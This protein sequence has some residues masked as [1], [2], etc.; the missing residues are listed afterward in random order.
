MN[1]TIK[2]FNLAFFFIAIPL[3]S[4]NKSNDYRGKN[5]NLLVEGKKAVQANNFREKEMAR[6]T[7]EYDKLK[8]HNA[9]LV[10][11][12]TKMTKDFNKQEDEH[13]EICEAANKL[14][15]RYTTLMARNAQLAT[16]NSN[17][18]EQLKKAQEQT[19]NYKNL[20]TKKIESLKLQ[21]LNK[22]KSVGLSAV[23]RSPVPSKLISYDLD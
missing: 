22:Y 10:I 16:E 4:M 5:T 9:L 14:S 17:L 2:F 18:R 3:F 11:S 7:K 15:D 23:I 13:R 21:L 19:F 20:K 12:N 1:F 8:A 6:L